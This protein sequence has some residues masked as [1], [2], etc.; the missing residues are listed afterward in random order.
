MAKTIEA[1]SMG[2]KIA[3]GLLVL[4]GILHC[5]AWT[6]YGWSD[7]MGAIVIYGMVYALLG[8][9]LLS[10]VGKIRYLAFL[11]TLVGVLAAYITMGSSA[12]KDE[13]M[14]L[15]IAIDLVILAILAISIW[16]GRIPKT[17]LVSE[18]E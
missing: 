16:K 7:G 14:W 15:S 18:L 4:T 12:I 17:P 1:W 5:F 8:G 6:V 10:R 3:G 9:L 11:V 13:L 2:L